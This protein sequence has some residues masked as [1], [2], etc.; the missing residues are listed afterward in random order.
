[1]KFLLRLTLCALAILG[2]SSIAAL[3]WDRSDE[4]AALQAG[5]PQTIT[6]R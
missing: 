2:A 5:T 6:T 3:A 1:M 4:A